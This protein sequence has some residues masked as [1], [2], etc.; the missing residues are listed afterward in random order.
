MLLGIVFGVLGLIVGSF[1]NVAILRFGAR[2][3]GGRS[4]CMS[5]GKQLQWY[6]MIPVFSWILLRGR[7][8][9]CRS[10][11]SIQYPLVEATTASL[12]FLLGAAPIPIELQI[13]GIFIISLL[14]AIAV[15]DLRHTIIPDAWAYGFAA[16]ALLFSIIA[17]A[18]L[19]NN[20]DIAFLFAS[21]PIVALPLFALWLISRGTWMGLGDAKLALGIGWLVGFPLGMTALLFAFILGAF[22][23][24]FILLPLPYLINALRIT[25]LGKREHGYTMKS[26]VPFGPFL[27][28]SCL[29]V[30]FMTLYGIPVPF[31][32]A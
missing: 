9:A 23:A 28:A 17:G 1:L 11:I 29:L 31:F 32:Y 15:Y 4:A 12:F 7:C 21:G 16:A 26:E 3:L 22:V 8:R 27:I 6:D 2:S 5:C 20:T 25:R 19:L 14:I 18:G 10:G 13:I 24:V 30:W